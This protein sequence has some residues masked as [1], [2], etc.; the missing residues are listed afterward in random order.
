M[1]ETDTIG[2]LTGA[3]AGA[4]YGSEGIPIEWLDDI[5]KL[6]ELQTM[7]DELITKYK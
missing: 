6:G 5:V 4:I 7:F 1:C 2:A 3:L